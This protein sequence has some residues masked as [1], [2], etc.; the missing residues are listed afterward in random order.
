MAHI[1]FSHFMLNISHSGKAGSFFHHLDDI[2]VF[3]LGC[4]VETVLHQ[5]PKTNVLSKYKATL[6]QM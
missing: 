2:S 4:Y 1:E 6:W 3:H 5:L